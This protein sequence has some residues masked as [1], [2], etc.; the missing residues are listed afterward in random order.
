T[1]STPGCKSGF[2]VDVQASSVIPQDGILSPSV[3]LVKM[4]KD[5]PE[6]AGS[7]SSVQMHTKNA[8][9]LLKPNLTCQGD[10]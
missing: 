6:K 2:Y 8:E 4:R 5:S 10:R 7:Y 9:G 3:G 1:H